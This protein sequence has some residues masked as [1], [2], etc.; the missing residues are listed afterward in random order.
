MNFVKLAR[1]AKD[2]VEETLTG[3]PAEIRRAADEVPVFF[4]PEPD[5]DDVAAGVEA[6]TL[7]LFD[8]GAPEAPTPRIRLWLLNIWDFAE[9]DVEVF[10]E[11]VRTTLLHELGH[12]FGWDEADLE[13]RGLS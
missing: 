6:D 5:E 12:F 4:E 3:R 9:E 7:G 10:R 13:E 8:E 1:V 2:V 11:E